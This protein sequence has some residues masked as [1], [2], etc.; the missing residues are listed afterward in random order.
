MIRN[1]NGVL[2]GALCINYDTTEIRRAQEILNY[3]LDLLQSNDKE[4]E[5]G[6]DNPENVTEIADKLIAQII[7]NVDIKSLKRK[8]KI[9]LIKFMDEKGIFLIK[10]S[11]ETVARLLNISTVTV[12][13][14]L[15]V[16]KK[17][18]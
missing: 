6:N 15:D 7:E 2:I 12:Y 10:G 14:Y 8:Q 18:K 3:N 11:V 1:S 16:I 5:D 17:G 13:S 4:E 9:E